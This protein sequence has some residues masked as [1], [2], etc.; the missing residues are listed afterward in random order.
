MS[1]RFWTVRVSLVVPLALLSGTCGGGG[2]GGK[3]CG[4]LA[5]RLE[6]CNVIPKGAEFL[7]SEAEPTSRSAGCYDDC[8]QNATCSDVKALF[9]GS[10]RDTALEQCYAKCERF[11]CKDGTT[12]G[13]NLLCDQRADCQDGSDEEGCPTFACK[14]G[15]AVDPDLR[16]DGY[17]DCDDGSDEAG[18]PTFTCKDGEKIPADW[19]CDGKGECDDDSDELDCPPSIE[20]IALCK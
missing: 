5:S 4:K 14:S 2:G 15:K 8:F 9:C 1:L 20:D 7:C 17:V 3:V 10:N 19:R 12:I 18:C 11:T 13:S 6:G 16:C